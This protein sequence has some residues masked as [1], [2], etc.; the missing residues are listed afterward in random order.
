MFRKN[1]GFI[2]FVGKKL[3]ILDGKDMNMDQKRYEIDKIPRIAEEYSQK[4]KFFSI[5]D[6]V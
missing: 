4:T 6:I 2:R 1:E 5:L 3:I